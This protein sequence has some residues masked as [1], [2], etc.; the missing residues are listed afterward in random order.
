M[1][2]T[3]RVLPGISTNATTS[4]HLSDERHPD[5][6]HLWLDLYRCPTGG[7]R[8]MLI[9]RALGLHS[10]HYINRMNFCCCLSPAPG[11]PEH[12]ATAQMLVRI[13][14]LKLFPPVI[15][16]RARFHRIVLAF[17]MVNC[18]PTQRIKGTMISATLTRLNKKTVVQQLS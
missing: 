5:Y 10:A 16:W 7:P 4:L 13:K 6:T 9:A 12:R 2:V 14:G 17:A 3:R 18:M 8:E 11:L 15:R 1:S